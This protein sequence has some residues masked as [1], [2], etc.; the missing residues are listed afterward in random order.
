MESFIVGL[1]Y[2]NKKSSFSSKKGEL[3]KLKFHDNELDTT[4]SHRLKQNHYMLT[5]F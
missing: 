1:I 5:V 4:V 2:E 3:W